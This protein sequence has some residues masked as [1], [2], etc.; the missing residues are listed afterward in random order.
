MLIWSAHWVAEM[1]SYPDKVAT[2]HCITKLALK[3]PVQHSQPGVL[4]D[5]PD[6]QHAGLLEA[7]HVMTSLPI[8]SPKL[9]DVIYLYSNLPG[10]IDE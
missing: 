7:N 9:I 8:S 10:I 2:F 1:R 4:S 5:L 6:G 3:F